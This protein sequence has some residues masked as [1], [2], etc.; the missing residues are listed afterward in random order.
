MESLLG[1]SLE[2]PRTMAVMSAVQGLLGGRGA[3]QG[4]ASGVQ[5]YGGTMQAAKQ[6]QAAEELRKMQLAQH[7]LQLKQM[8]DAAAQQAM[9]RQL[10]Q[11]ALSPI[12]GIEANRASGITGPRP[13]ALGVVGQVP[14]FDPRQFVSQGGSLQGAASVAQLLAKDDAPQK[15][16]P[17]EL[18]LSGKAS[19]YKPLAANPKEDTTPSALKEYNFA[20]AQ[21][22]PGSFLDFQL[23]QKR[24]G[25]TNVTVS[26]EKGYGEKIAGGMAERDLAAI[27]AAKAA[28]DA[29]ASAQRIRTILSQQKPITGAGA[30]ARLAI[31]KALYAAGMTKGEDVVAT[32]NLQ[33]EL[34]QGVLSHIKSSG[35]GGGNGFSNADRDFLEKAAAGTIG[36]NALTL[37]RTA[38]LTEKAARKSIEAGNTALK[39]VKSAPGLGTLPLMPDVQ[40]PDGNVIDFAS[41]K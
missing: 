21:G 10:T 25:A 12:R 35:L 30:D 20:K 3:L 5:A 1:T 38:E 40:Q 41:L 27:D 14:A 9:D 33:R 18:L 32:E 24:A 26:T 28:P 17:G 4:I 15:L 19:G 22:Y 6:Q 13:E 11:T 29:I 39:R 23:A 31:S 36:V 37:A 8:Q 16:A 34:S 2:D 7:A